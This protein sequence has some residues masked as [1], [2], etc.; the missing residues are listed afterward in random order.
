[1]KDDKSTG[2]MDDL[3]LML[4]EDEELN[5]LFREFNSGDKEVIWH[6]FRHI[7]KD[8]LIFILSLH[9][10]N[11]EGMRKFVNEEIGVNS[12]RQIH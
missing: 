9:K 3:L 12:N 7:A 8:E 11:K 4:G 2:M 6:Y 10:N 5:Q 1:M